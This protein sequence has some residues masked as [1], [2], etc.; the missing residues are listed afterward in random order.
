MIEK[1]KTSIEG[2]KQER[3][4]QMTAKVMEKRERGQVEYR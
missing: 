1:K 2:A 4:R 3:S